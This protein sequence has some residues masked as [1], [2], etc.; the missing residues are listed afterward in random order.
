[1]TGAH[2][3]AIVGGVG[4]ATLTLEL[5]RRRQLRDK[6]AV[7]FLLLAIGMLVIALAPGLLTWIAEILSIVEPASALFFVAL[8]TLLAI[9]A[10]LSWEISRLEQETRVLAEEVALLR[11]E[12]ETP[13][14]EGHAESSHRHDT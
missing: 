14:D 11:L 3:I 5:V 8:L 13:A 10:H 4:S 1:M 6:Y 2:L 9:V 12:M 7:L